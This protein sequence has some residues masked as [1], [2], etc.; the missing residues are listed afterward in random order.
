ME[1][2]KK[3]PL[4]RLGRQKHADCRG[5]LLYVVCGLLDTDCSDEHGLTQLKKKVRFA[6]GEK[7]HVAGV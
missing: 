2:D 6:F 3:I 4:D 5:R 7:G 1:W